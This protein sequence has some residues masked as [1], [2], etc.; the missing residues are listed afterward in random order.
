MSV[1]FVS[2]GAKRPAMAT[3]LPAVFIVGLLGLSTG[4]RVAGVP[5]LEAT[6]LIT[7]ALLG[8]WYVALLARSRVRGQQLMVEFNAVRTHYVQ[9]LVQSSVYIYWATAWPFIAGQF[10]LIF[11]QWCFAYACTMLIAWTRRGKAEVGFG[12]L[13]II[14]STNF[15]LCF[16]DEWFYLQFLM[17]SLGI[18]GKEFNRWQRDGRSTHIFNPSVL[19]LSVAS[20]IVIL[21]GNTDL[22]WAE[23]YAIELGRPDHIYLWIFAVGLV[24]QYL[25]E[26]TLVTF[27]AAGTL[28]MLNL[29][30]TQSTGVYWFLDSGIPIA[31][32]LGL[33][34][35]VTDPA[36]SPRDNYG[37]AIFGALYGAGVFLLYLVLER[38]GLPR[39]YDKLLFIPLLNL[40]VPLID[41]YARGTRLAHVQP[42]AWIGSLD[43]RRQN[44]LFMGVWI[45]TFAAMYMT[46]VV[47]PGHPGKSADF[48]HS[49][50]QAGRQNGCV[51]ERAIDQ[52]GCSAGH[53]S[54]CFDLAGT[55]GAPGF[56]PAAP[57][58]KAL[59]L[60]RACDLT[61]R[62]GCRLFGE[63]N[64]RDAGAA[65][66]ARCDAR[67][68]RSCYALG[69]ASLLGLGVDASREH[70]AEFFG[71]ACDLRSAPGC[72]N[73]AEIYRFGVGLPR[74]LPNAM[75]QYDKA[76]ALGYAPACVRLA[77]VLRAGGDVPR[78]EPRADA[79]VDRACKLVPD[80][81]C[82]GGRR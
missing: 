39:F 59:A 23:Q 64:G 28:W 71:R 12:P 14:L 52:S 29:V 61:D 25:F 63:E 15:F 53:V 46:H 66:R 26:V 27:A 4:S 40:L 5:G 19:G 38:A 45:A 76:C 62:D 1:T 22:T 16:K 7:A 24:V 36:T 31:V 21:T 60:A 8:L 17:I 57:Q 68:A 51:N 32:F 41:R 18:F 67:D 65:L 6:F 50:C 34:L 42:F 44:L 2:V 79:L 9:A 49:A 82:P 70:A 43:R 48:W 56:P 30:Y 73:L 72:G 54:A 35:L 58:V 81:T 78:N 80:S 77:E 47:G 74:S 11:A 37:R 10:P 33:H 3:L 13:P 20:L 69:T 55:V 75:V